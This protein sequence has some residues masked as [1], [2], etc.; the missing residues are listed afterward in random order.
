VPNEESE[1]SNMKYAM[2]GIFLFVVV[3][4]SLI[5][6]VYGQEKGMLAY[7][8]LKGVS[9]PDSA[10]VGDVMKIDAEFDNAGEE[11]VS[12]I[13]MGEIYLDYRLVESVKSDEFRVKPGS[14][15]NLTTYFTPTMAG[16]YHIRG[17]VIYS[18][19]ESSIKTSHFTVT[20]SPEHEPKLISND[21]TVPLAVDSLLALIII[22]FL[23]LFRRRSIR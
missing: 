4:F 23:L 21:L 1:G 22:T 7:G 5:A 3:F 8:M 20:A 2:V 17:Y 12:A 11:T 15:I 16:D 19:R 14:S 9:H 13:F 18:G 6:L 10:A